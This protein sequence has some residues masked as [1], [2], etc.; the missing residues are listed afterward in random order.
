MRV[1]HL[2]TFAAVALMSTTL[3]AQGARGEAQ[4]ARGAALA[5]AADK[6][7]ATIQGAWVVNS[8]NDRAQAA[9]SMVF[10]GETASSALIGTQAA[11]WARVADGFTGFVAGSF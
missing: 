1:R 3:L 9:M 7:L 2:F 10:K 11:L 4:G 6:A 5:P 8:I